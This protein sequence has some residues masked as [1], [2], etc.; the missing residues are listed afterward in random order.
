M[1]N[2]AKLVYI[3]YHSKKGSTKL[4]A[5][6]IMDVFRSLFPKNIQIELMNVD[7]IDMDGLK[8]ADGFVIGSP[9]YFS[10]PSGK[11]KT[12]FDELYDIRSE[13]S[14]RPSFGFITHGGSGK[15]VKPL[16][17]LINSIKLKEVGPVIEVKT[18][19]IS[20]KHESLIQKNCQMMIKEL[21]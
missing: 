17:S 21:E 16:S 12:I 18:T 9:D 5:Q 8:K 13:L 2:M 14:G 20:S 7:D 4:L 3:V 15:A 10:Y 11:I 19:N 1:V 6:R